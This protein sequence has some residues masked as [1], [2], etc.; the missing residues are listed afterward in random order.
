MALST[1]DGLIDVHAHYTTPHYVA[2]AMANGHRRP[3]GMPEQAWPTW[4]LEAQLDFMDSVGIAQSYLSISSPGV[5]F[6]DDALAR[7]LAREVND[8]AAALV[9]AHP[10][11]FG[12]FAS[13]PL[14]DIDG[15]CAELCRAVD[16][17]GA[18]GAIML[19]NA[20]GVYLGNPSLTPV[21]EE[22]DRRSSVLLVHPTCAPGS[23]KVACGRPGPM[24]EFM[25]DT[26]RSILDYIL[27]GA[28]QRFPNIKVIVPDCG[29]VL[30]LLIDRV[31]LFQSIGQTGEHEAVSAALRRFYV[32]LAGR[33]SSATQIVAMNEVFSSTHVL[34]GS[35]FPWTPA[36][37]IAPSVRK[38]D[39]VLGSNWRR[40]SRDNADRLMGIGT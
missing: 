15:G 14:P 25:F 24:I 1:D 5:H 36:E 6:G 17:L 23:D 27:S 38:L 39:G 34:Y 4:T 30:P 20:G 10:D 26:A 12:F 35:D 3:D 9:E 29:G 2:Q 18:Q 28:A 7:T 16:D 32:E 22:L 37:T 21:L 11:R 40:R 31:N 19:S 33:P 13:M 8:A